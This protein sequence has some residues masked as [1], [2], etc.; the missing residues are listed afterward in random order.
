MHA[1]LV[2]PHHMVSESEA[3]PC[4][5]KRWERWLTYIRPPLRDGLVC[6]SCTTGK[7]P[8][9]RLLLPPFLPLLLVTDGGA[10]RREGLHDRDNGGSMAYN[11]EIF[12]PP[13]TGS[14][15]LPQPLPQQLPQSLPQSLQLP[16]S[17]KPGQRTDGEM[18]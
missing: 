8:L 15:P 18:A 7:P 17:V 6:H 14:L 13:M 1:A 4:K 11:V 3:Q 10:V 9:P 2:I 16:E 12:D 5:E